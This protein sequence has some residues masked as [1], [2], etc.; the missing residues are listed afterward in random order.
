MWITMWITFSTHLIRVL[1]YY[2]LFIWN[3]IHMNNYSCINILF[4]EYI[5]IY[6]LLC[7]TWNIIV[8]FLSISTHSLWVLTIIITHCWRVLTVSTHSDRLLTS[9]STHLYWVITISTHTARVLTMHSYADICINILCEKNTKNVYFFGYF[10][11][12]Y[13]K[14][15]RL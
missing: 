12:G 6:F 11:L 14:N 10:L 8:I 5:Y 4:Y 2:N 3:N 13:H 7:F 9:V 15:T 1:T